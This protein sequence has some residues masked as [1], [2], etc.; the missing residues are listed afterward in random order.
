MSITF[1]SYGSRAQEEQIQFV[2]T[3]TL[4]SEGQIL[5]IEKYITVY[6][7]IFCAE[8]VMTMVHVIILKHFR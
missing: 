2:F 5:K 7:F 6:H 1:K 4:S 8:F 3:N